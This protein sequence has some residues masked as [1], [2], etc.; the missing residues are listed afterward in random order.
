MWSDHPLSAAC[1]VL[2]HSERERVSKNTPGSSGD[3]L[4]GSS[5][6]GDGEAAREFT[7][8]AAKEAK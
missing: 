4:Y 5:Y 2:W 1:S 3:G 7:G 8:G 6:Y